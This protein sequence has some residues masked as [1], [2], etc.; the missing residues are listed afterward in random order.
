[1]RGTIRTKPTKNI[2]GNGNEK[3]VIIGDDRYTIRTKPTKDIFGDGNELEIKHH[4]QVNFKDSAAS[5]L[6][7]W[8]IFAIILIFISP[9][10]ALKRD[11]AETTS[12]WP[13]LCFVS[14]IILYIISCIKDYKNYGDLWTLKAVIVMVI[15]L[16]VFDLFIMF[17]MSIGDFHIAFPISQFFI[18]VIKWI[19][20][21]A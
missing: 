13:G 20:V 6:N 4:R 5:L 14:S 9:F 17:M 8:C 11:I 12:I 19:F 15:F 1:M 21:G 16:F 18:N 2:F 7:K 10:L 3:E